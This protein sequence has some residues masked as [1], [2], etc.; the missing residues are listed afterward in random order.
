[1]RADSIRRGSRRWNLKR[2]SNVDLGSRYQRFL[3]MPAF[4]RKSARLHLF[5]AR[6][7]GH[8]P[9]PVGNP[10]LDARS[11]ATEAFGH[12]DSLYAFAWRLAHDAQSADDLVQ[13]TFTR[14][15]ASGHGL[16]AG[17]NLKA[18]LFRVLRNAFIDQRRREARNPIRYASDA[19]EL[20][21]AADSGKELEQLRNL[22]AQDIEAALRDLPEEQ[23]IVV[24]LDLE[25]FSE[26][27]IAEV[28]GCAPGTVKS[29]LSRA[30]AALR[31][32]LQEYAR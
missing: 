11:L 2:A 27:E 25:G 30:R 8:Y 7:T 18:W 1:M 23:T 31:Q 4:P 19:A 9:V 21:L 10:E 16:P 17:S 26:L 6:E 13:E 3:V 29:R 22:Q 28:M 5:P 24:L 20:D 14:C 32:R 12:L 15:L